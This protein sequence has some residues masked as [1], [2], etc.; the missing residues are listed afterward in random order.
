MPILPVTTVGLAAANE[1]TYTWA[2]GAHNILKVVG[3][4]IQ[5]PD[6]NKVLCQLSTDGSTFLSASDSYD[7]MN[8][9]YNGSAQTLFG[10][11]DTQTSM[12]LFDN[13]GSTGGEGLGFDLTLTDIDIAGSE[14]SI[15]F[16]GAAED[17][18]SS[19]ATTWGFG[20]MNSAGQIRG[21]R[22]FNSSGGNFIRGDLLI[23]AWSSP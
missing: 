11:V 16:E 23:Y 5:P 13:V 9:E 20:R 6:T 19:Q 2:L 4:A 8:N 15:M 22:I 3:Y 1:G 17:A 18:A 7:W 14:S 12:E 10:G 21:I